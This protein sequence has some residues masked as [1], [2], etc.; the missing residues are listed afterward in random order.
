MLYH[1]SQ[2]E[3]RKTLHILGLPSRMNIVL[4]GQG[5]LEIPQLVLEESIGALPRLPRLQARQTEIAAIRSEV[6]QLPAVQRVNA[7]LAVSGGDIHAINY[8]STAWNGGSKDFNYCRLGARAPVYEGTCV[9]AMPY[10]L[11]S[12]E[13]AP[14]RCNTFPNGTTLSGL[15][16][17]HQ[18][19]LQLD[20]NAVCECVM[21]ELQAGTVRHGCSTTRFST[22]P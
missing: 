1:V 15:A 13:T 7:H 9:P 16:C 17:T 21:E 5:Y 18:I 19:D 4:F 3:A 10:T 8:T 2:C 6:D 11:T 12:V 14:Y 20:C 22:L